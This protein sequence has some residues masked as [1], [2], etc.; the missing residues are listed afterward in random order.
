MT[1]ELRNCEATIFHNAFPHKLYKVVHKY[2][3]PPTALIMQML[4]A[5]C[6][7]SAT[8]MHSLLAHDITQIDLARLTMNFDQCYALCIQKH[9]HR[10]HFTVGGN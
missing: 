6:K 8:V 10:P 9:N 1:A 4:S 5:Y 7:L 3:W 2:R